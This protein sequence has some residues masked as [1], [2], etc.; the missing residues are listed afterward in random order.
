MEIQRLD[1]C[2][3]CKGRL[4][5]EK[6]QYGLYE[7]CMECGYIYDLQ[8]VDFLDVVKAEEKKAEAAQLVTEESS[9]NEAQDTPQLDGYSLVEHLTVPPD[10]QSIL[11]RLPK[12]H[13]SKPQQK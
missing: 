5:R 7:Q 11:N 10:L 6:D 9:D 12:E 3:R 8:T 13:Q 1:R 4:M 2:P